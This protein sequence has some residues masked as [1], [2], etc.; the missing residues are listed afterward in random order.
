MSQGTSPFTAQE[1]QPQAEML[2]V[3][4]GKGE[5]FIGIP[6]ERQHQEKRICLTP[7]AVSALTAHGHRVMIEKG[8][9]AGSSFS[10][11]SYSE[12][13]A[14]VTADTKRVYSCP[15]ILKVEP[16][17]LEEIEWIKPETTVISAIQIKTQHKSY[18]SALSKKQVTA[19]AFEFIKDD[20]GQHPAVCAL[21]EIAGRASVL[22]ASELMSNND[23]DGRGRLFGNINGVPPT[24][25]VIL[26]AGT[27]G[28]HAAKTA[29]GLGASVR[30]FD[31]SISRL[32]RAKTFVGQEFYT[33]TVQPKY[34]TKSLRRCDVAIGALKGTNRAPVVVTEQ[35][36]DK[37]KPGSIIIDVSIDMGGCFETSEVTNH[38]KPTFTR[39]GVIHYGVP[40]IPSRYSR[41]AT[42]SLSNIFTPYLLQIA[43]NGGIEH[44]IRQDLGLR[45]GVYLYHGVLTNKIVGDWFDLDYRDPNLLIF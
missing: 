8:A 31:N 10:D 40:N 24:Q 13:G 27:V 36:V 17:T 34:L 1:L 22:I 6:K 42:L 9:G 14:E 15:L 4:H 33:S 23:K 7:D 11:I 44:A 21:S 20:T 45:S 39:N 19:L 29:I 25:V 35:M 38:D 2:E 12:A 5:L 37:M 18:F 30:M 28:S 41:T 16:L 32:K 3:Q 43:D 26:G